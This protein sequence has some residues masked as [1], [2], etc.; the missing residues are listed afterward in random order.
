MIHIILLI[1]KIIGIILLVIFG[2][3]LLILL[4]PITYMGKAEGCGKQIQAKVR[5]GWLFHFV[6]F[7]LTFQEGQTSYKIRL[8]GIPIYSS[9]GEDEDESKERTENMPQSDFA[10]DSK[11]DNLKEERQQ[12]E[13]SDEE[14]REETTETKKSENNEMHDS[15]WN[16]G[17][18]EES[19][20]QKKSLKDFCEKI[21]SII[22]SIREKMHHIGESIQ[23]AAKK[24]KETNDFLKANSTK[25]A[26]RYA[27]KIIKKLLKHIF[28]KRIRA[29]VVYGMEA[30]DVTGKIYGYIAM[31]YAAFGLNPK[32][33]KVLPDFQEKKFEGEIRAG[34][35]IILGWVGILALKFYF[36]KEIHDIIK[37]RKKK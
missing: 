1:L 31:A 8:L 32:K 3:L 30:P 33:V 21:K 29:N 27:K 16:D 19:K 35:Y 37:Q 13:K 14:L 15:V 22:Q 9:K 10:D 26:Y 34:G 24:V 7:G 25:K 36:Y 2:L 12:Q 18:D 23:S 4:F 28:P 5:A 17:G 6:H 20:R 11:E